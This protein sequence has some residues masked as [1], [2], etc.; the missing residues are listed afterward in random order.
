MERIHKGNGNNYKYK[1][2]SLITGDNSDI[3]HGQIFETAIWF[4]GDAERFQRNRKQEIN[5]GIE[6]HIYLS[7]IQQRKA[8]VPKDKPR[9]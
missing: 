5:C 6:K 3:E 4:D 9:A 8:D 7:K 1:G 2:K